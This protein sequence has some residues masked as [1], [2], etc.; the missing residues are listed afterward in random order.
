MAKKQTSLASLNRVA[1][2]TCRDVDLIHALR[3]AIECLV[4]ANQ[5]VNL[6]DEQTALV[7]WSRLAIDVPNGGFTQFF[8]NLRGD[9]GIKPLCKLLKA[10][11]V[12][13][14]MKSLE[15][16]VAVYQRHRQRFQVENPWEGLFG[17]IPEF[18]PLDKAF[19]NSG[20]V[21]ANRALEKWIRSHIE[22]LAVGDDGQPLDPAFTGTVEIKHPNG[23]VQESLEVK[24]GKPNGAYREFF[25]D[26]SV[27]QAAF[28]KSGQL[29]GDFWP[30]GQVKKNEMKRGQHKVT[31]W[32][33]PSGKLQKRIV[34]DKRGKHVEPVRFFYE[35][36]QLAE[37]LTLPAHE[38]GGKWLKYFEDGSPKLEA[39]FVAKN[40]EIIHNAWD[41]DRRQV[42]TN[43]TGVFDDDGRSIDPTHRLVFQSQWR[44]VSERKKG[45]RHGKTTTYNNGVLWSVESY[46]SG[47]RDG[48]STDYWDNG[49]VRTIAKYKAD[50]EVE[51]R[52]YPKFDRPVPAVQL[53]LEASE[54]LYSAWRHIAVD[55]YP[56]A[57]NL[58]TIRAK[59]KIPKFLHEVHERNVAGA[60]KSDYED[61]SRFKDGITYFLTVDT[62]GKVTSARASGSSA[63]SG[64]E[65]D[66]YVPLLMQLQFKPGRIRGRSVE[67]RVLA[68][69]DHTFVE[70][71]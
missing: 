58:A 38:K 1:F 51:S 16:A 35:S 36:G 37:E 59:L 10:V 64:G 34:T 44:Y 66:T 22:K 62:T 53:N 68:H 30:S 50:E 60:L 43:G 63:Y 31:E 49:R 21:A 67:C 24:N 20:V 8:Y 41:E 9:L 29:S 42:V 39:E 13:K 14:P 52:K 33:Y 71:G 40:D 46:T 65:W 70:G 61:A 27:R 7:A 23:V 6:S 45:V 25:D 56:V 11:G 48:E 28:Y 54:K 19:M 69:V 17:G 4:K 15:Q 47:Q 18:T 55:E 5:S 12:A 26:G 57:K 32:Y 2:F 3:R